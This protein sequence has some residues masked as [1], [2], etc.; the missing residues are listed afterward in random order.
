M[1]QH[2]TEM[3]RQIDQLSREVERLKRVEKAR[4]RD[5]S[6]G[7]DLSPS[8]VTFTLAD[9]AI[10]SIA[11]GALTGII[12]IT[13]DSTGGMALFMVGYFVTFEIL[14]PTA[15]FSTT[16]GTAGQN[17]VYKSGL[18]TACQVEN[19]TGA[20]RQYTASVIRHRAG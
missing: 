18:G 13:N 10:A 15:T 14:D 3:Q 5:F 8:S 16:A 7:I 11:G 19:K 6:S 12:I 17:N 4:F 1:A 9:N 20:T 2:L